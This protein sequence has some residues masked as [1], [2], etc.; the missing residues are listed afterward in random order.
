MPA[1]GII[2]NDYGFMDRLRK[3]AIRSPRLAFDMMRW[4]G[5]RAIE[6]ARQEYLSGQ[7]LNAPTGNL[8]SR[9][10]HDVGFSGSLTVKSILW[11]DVLYAPVHELGGKQAYP[12]FPKRAKAL[13]WLDRDGTPVF[14]KFVLNHPPAKKRAF[15][16]PS[17]QKA[18]KQ[19]VARTLAEIARSI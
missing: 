8:M 17:A 15:L 18:L 10:Y 3:L 13:R 5:D 1:E 12:I 7:V 6:I 4:T 14:R 16:V 2:V 11:T 9:L 19:G